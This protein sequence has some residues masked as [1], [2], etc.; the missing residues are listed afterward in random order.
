MDQE[1]LD[2]LE[3]RT[4]I[5]KW[6]ITRDASLWDEFRTVWHEDG[7]MTATWI[8]TPFENFIAITDKAIKEKGLNIM[9]HVGESYIKVKGTRAVTQTRFSILQRAMV[10]GIECDVTC[11]ARHYDFWEKRD[12]RWGLVLRKTIADKDRI[13]PV[14]SRDV[15][16]LDKD[17]LKQFPEEYKHLGYLQSKIGYDV[18]RNAPCRSGGEALEK[19]YADGDRWLRGD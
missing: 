13:D 8:E 15:V 1:I 10:E 18:E 12:T 5:E 3:L 2:R 7:V 14:D 9:H 6:A 16:E 17:Y 11:Y 4:L 19:L